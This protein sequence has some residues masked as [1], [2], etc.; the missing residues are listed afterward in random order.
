MKVL[1]G[2]LFATM[3]STVSAQTTAPGTVPGIDS[4]VVEATIGE[5]QRE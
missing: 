3:V 4:I 5:L 2:L 1:I